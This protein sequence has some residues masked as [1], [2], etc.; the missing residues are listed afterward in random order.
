[1]K[2]KETIS[3]SFFFRDPTKLWILNSNATSAFADGRIPVQLILE[4]VPL[5][6]RA[7]D[8]RVSLRS[9]ATTLKLEYR[10]T[11]ASA[12]PNVSDATIVFA[13]PTTDTIGALVPI[14]HIPSHAIS[15]P[16]EQ[17]FTY[18]KSP[19]PT[20]RS[21]VPSAVPYTVSSF[22]KIT[23]DLFPGVLA[24]TDVSVKIYW[25][26]TKHTESAEVLSFSR[27]DASVHPLAVQGF[28]FNIKTPKG[29][30]GGTDIVEGLATI[31]VYHNLF[32]ARQ[33]KRPGFVFYDPS[34]PQ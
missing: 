25:T 12:A 16:F 5:G 26:K 18:L 31:S 33:A 24:A 27:T 2:A 21:L 6:L 4:N 30:Q 9:N 7:E 34:R 32:S 17:S 8:I 10:A 15:L 13:V 28:V 20:V 1:M 29:A 23:V 3:F 11:A 14:L 22:V 19:D